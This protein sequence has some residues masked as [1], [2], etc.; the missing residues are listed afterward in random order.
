MVPLT[1]S[2]LLP[3]RRSRCPIENPQL[4]WPNGYGDQ[5]LYRVEVELRQGDQILDQREYTIGLRT[6]ELRRQLDRWGQSFTFVVN[7][8]PIFAK[9]SN[10]IPS[11]SFPTRVTRAQLDFLIASAAQANHNMLR[12]WGGGYYE[13]EAFYDLCDRYGVLVWQDFM[14]ACAGYPL[15]NEAFLANVKIESE[16]V[17][18]RLRHHACLALWCGNNE[19]ESGWVSWNWDTPAN[20]DLKAADQEFF[21]GTLPALIAAHDPDRPYWP[22]SPSSGMPHEDPNSNSDGRQSPVGSVARPEA[23][24]LLSRAV[25]AL[26]QRVWHAV[27]ARAVDRRHLCRTGRVEHDVVRHGASSAAHVRQ[28]QD[29]CLSHAELLPAQ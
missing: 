10:W 9:G 8:V 16:Q 11:D 25:S 20:A 27:A 12:V 13:D 4:W 24:G 3:I 7:G 14:Y 5:P 15:N 29:H 17:V 21:Y 26:R 6:I 22:S 23:A 28:R 18:Q 2:N 1:R 19:M